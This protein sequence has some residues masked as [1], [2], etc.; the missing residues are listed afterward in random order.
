LWIGATLSSAVALYQG[1][2]D[3]E[4]L[5]T[6]FWASA[7][8]T[9]G[10]MLDANAF[11]M[12]AAI[13]GPVAFSIIRERLGIWPAALVLIVNTAGV[14][15]SGS[16][17]A[18]LCA[19][20]GSAA[21]V[22][23]TWKSH[24]G[25]ARRRYA[26][27]AAATAALLLIVVFAAGA[28][29]PARRLAELPDTPAAAL[30]EVL[31]RGPYGTTALQILRDFPASGVGIGAYQ[32]IAP[33]YWRR[34]ADDVLPFD[35]AQN[36]WRHQAAELGIIGGL[37][38]F[39]WSAVIAW[40]VATARAAPGVGL[41]SITHMPTQTPLVLLW[42]LLLLG[43]F[44]VGLTE[45]VTAR[46]LLAASKPAA[47]IAAV[48]LAVGYAAIQIGHAEG[49]LD[50]A[51]RARRTSREYIVGTYPPELMPDATFFRW[52]RD[53]ARLRMPGRAPWLV[54]RLWAHHP[55]VMSDPVRVAVST[56]CGVIAEQVLKTRK[57]FSI[58]LRVPP[59]SWLDFSVDVSRTWRPSD[60][61]GADGR[62]LGVGLALDFVQDLHEF[63]GPDDVADL[64]ACRESPGGPL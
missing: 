56:P 26:L 34:V 60:F 9:T 40:T 15:M 62:R 54:I 17:T 10:T 11:G 44:C 46:P 45:P 61:G 8:R 50:V 24:G 19:L 38:P 12:C 43:W 33:D 22:A 7:A 63:A 2:V 27:G 31:T 59:E 4:F 23:A 42:F 41:A 57:P 49:R 29:G 28:V 20:A 48:A 25:G 39:I 64:P 53:R 3:L 1:A 55:D 47:W 37:I 6:P 35:T 52:T 5:S 32:L 30:R 13:A 14:W 18:A 51:E 58:W 21:V 16:R 36:W